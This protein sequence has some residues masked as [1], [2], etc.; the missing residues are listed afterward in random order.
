VDMD[1]INNLTQN[2]QTPVPTEESGGALILSAPSP[3]PSASPVSSIG[4]ADPSTPVSALWES[5]APDIVSA[6]GNQDPFSSQ[7][8][9]QQQHDDDDE[10]GRFTAEEKGKGKE[11]ER[12]RVLEE[13]EDVQ[14]KNQSEQELASAP[15][16]LTS[17]PFHALMG[18]S[19]L[20]SNDATGTKPP[21]LDLSAL[22]SQNLPFALPTPSSCSSQ[23]AQKKLNK[24]EIIQRAQERKKHLEEELGRI[25][26]QLWETTIEQSVLIELQKE[27]LP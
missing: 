8:E 18:V 16:A 10:V 6:Q 26:M 23:P 1:K 11:K 27:V 17:T 25:K 9:R 20:P 22:R 5:S 7:G 14:G 12:E 21:S 4:D 2:D 3:M 24:Q 13:R 19:S 15:P